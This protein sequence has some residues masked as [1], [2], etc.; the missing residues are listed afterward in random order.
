[1]TTRA[2]LPAAER[3]IHIVGMNPSM[4]RTEEVPRFRAHEVN[5]AIRSQPRAG[6]KGLIVARALRRLGVEV[7]VHGFVGGAVGEYF[8]SECVKLGITD[9]QTSILGETRI[10]TIVVDGVTG[11]STVINEPGPSITEAEA[12]RFREA[13]LA[14]V[15]SGD[16][17]AFCGSLPLG[18]PNRMYTT[19]VRACAERGALT[20]VDAEGAVLID[21][22]EAPPWAIKCNLEEFT[23]LAPE[24]GPVWTGEQDGP[25]LVA[26]IRRVLD[27]G[28]ELVIVTM[29]AEGAIAVTRDETVRV[30]PAPIEVRNATGSGDTF[31]AG[32]LASAYRGHAFSDAL[33]WGSAAAAANA[34][35][36][37]PDIGPEPDLDS[38][39]CDVAV[40]KHSAVGKHTHAGTLA[41][42][43]A[44]KDA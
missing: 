36:I 15:A 34:A 42:I 12:E 31:L 43:D 5:R 11:A 25:A 13:L 30:K 41:D 10:N 14:D 33:R 38:L 39:L 21:A 4:D 9:R 32:V 27:R 7:S 37:I 2:W 28:V 35:T 17:V 18:I 8:R 29:G 23:A 19:L 6:G 3:A 26:A 40:I 44:V 24:V 20:V 16:L 22:A 1:M